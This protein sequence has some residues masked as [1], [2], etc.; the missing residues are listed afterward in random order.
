M[1]EHLWLR[2]FGAALVCALIVASSAASTVAKESSP[3]KVTVSDRPIDR[4]SQ[5]A[6]YAPIVK[7][8][9][10]SVVNIYSTRKVRVQPFSMPFM[11]DPMFRRFFGDQSERGRGP[12]TRN[13]QSLGSGV[14]VSE[15]GY[16][17]TSDHV[18]KGADEVEV[19]LSDGKTKYSARIVGR[20]P[21]TDVAV[22]KVDAKKLP[23]V[24]LADSD[25]LEVGDVVLAVGN[26]FGVGQSASKGI[27]SALGRAVGILG[28]H[29][30]ED[31]IQT[32][33]PIN[34]GNSGGALVDTEGRLVGINQSII[35]GGGG[36]A[37]A[38]VGFA[39]PINLARFAMDRLVTDGSIARG[40]LGVNIQSVTPELAKEFRVPDEAGAL[41]GNVQ[42]DTPAADAGLKEGDVIIEFNGKKVNDSR[43]LRLMVGETRPKTK[44]PLKILRDGREKTVTVTLGALPAELG[45]SGDTGDQSSVSQSDALD[46]VEVADLD[47]QARRQFDIPSHVRGALVT[48]VDP[49]SPAADAGL[50]E[51]DVILEIDRQTVRDAEQAVNLSEKVKGD[52]VLLRV[53]SNA[54]G[55]GGARYL[56]VE[57]KKKK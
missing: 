48:R 29:G 16:I 12:S 43:H 13:L 19:V 28:E 54:G 8:V 47:P 25:K 42:P 56:S 21:Q 46:G 17:L 55:S 18:V 39:V 51:G 11:D 23:A 9:T 7:K 41:V 22:V 20:D 10:P 33:A 35:S 5:V 26:P 38:G 4:S 27:I 53:W 15:D 52:H 24:T 2:T 40:Y 1:K 3:P 31:F 57:I 30:Y 44:V 37:N 36:M 34:P 49:D 45:G 6:S 32:D 50:R 14:I